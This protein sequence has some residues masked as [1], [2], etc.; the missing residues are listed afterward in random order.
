LIFR[1]DV[2][3]LRLLDF[4]KILDAH[5]KVMIVL[6]MLALHMLLVFAFL[7]ALSRDP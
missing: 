5:G 3:C 6:E 2:L 4:V 7:A 1:K